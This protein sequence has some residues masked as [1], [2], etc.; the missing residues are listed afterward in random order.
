FDGYVLHHVTLAGGI[1]RA[2]RNGRRAVNRLG[3]LD[4]GTCVS[5]CFE[6]VEA[7][8]VQDAV[9]SRIARAPQALDH[10]ARQCDEH[11]GQRRLVMRNASRACVPRVTIIE[12]PSGAMAPLM[13][14]ASE[15]LVT[16]TG[17]DAPRR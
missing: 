14:T 2:H 16:W 6:T 8:H 13:M 9:L 12:R 17:A 15:K 5:T 7:E 1:R 11:G 3:R 10:A 4:T